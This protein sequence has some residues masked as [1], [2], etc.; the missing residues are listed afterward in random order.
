M[1]MVKIWP[2]QNLNPSNDYDKIDYV[3]ETN[4]YQNLVQIG[5]EGAS[6]QMRE[7]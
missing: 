5:R 2:Q 7:I 3:R 6:G 4:S 1:G